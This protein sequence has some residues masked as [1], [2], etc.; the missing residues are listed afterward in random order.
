MNDDSG[1]ATGE[2]NVTGVRRDSSEVERLGV[3]DGDDVEGDEQEAG[4]RNKMKYTERKGQ[5]FSDIVKCTACMNYAPVF[6][7]A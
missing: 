2:D 1:E 5:L 6:V 3:R 4:S 7:L